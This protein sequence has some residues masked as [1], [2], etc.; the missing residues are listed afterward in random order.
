[1]RLTDLRHAKVKTIDGETIGRVFEVHADGG[2]ITALVC[3]ATGFLERLTSKT[4]GRR[5]PWESV[6][7]I[8]GKEIVVGEPKAS[9]ARSRQGTRRPSARRSKR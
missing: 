2:R 4:Q 8:S 3:G 9:A 7:R 1:M 5:I 6:R